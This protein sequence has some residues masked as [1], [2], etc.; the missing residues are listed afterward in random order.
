MIVI[1]SHRTEKDKTNNNKLKKRKWE[2]KR[3]R[4]GQ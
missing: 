4:I 3:E 2:V 1:N